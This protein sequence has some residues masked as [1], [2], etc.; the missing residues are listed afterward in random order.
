MPLAELIRAQ[1]RERELLLMTHIV[2]GHPDWETSL[3]LVDAMVAAGVELIELQLPFS[4]PLADGPW[5]ARASQQAV[6]RGVRVDDC[7][8]F[9]Q[10]VAARH[11]I[12][13]LLMSYYN[14][15]GRR[16]VGSFVQSSARAGVAGVIVPDLP[17]EESDEYVAAMRG[18][19]LAPI[20]MLSPRTPEGRLRALG[21][22]GDG[23]VYAVARTGVTGSQ[24]ELSP[25][26]A[27][28]LARCRAATE[29]P[30]A[31]GFGLKTR[32]DVQFLVGKADIAIVGSQ[33]LAVL[34]EGGVGAV[35]DFLVSL[36]A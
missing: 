16:G 29:L 2:I 22:A 6:Q 8:A 32:D 5:I 24:T 20:F 13:F 1:R 12:S 7:F 34:E 35:K 4:E 15:V 17:L 18:A 21:R 33:S 10:R 14:L 23:L 11:P 3:A 28:Y 19:S 26:L 27:C 9:A 30:L 36:R 31:V 25:E